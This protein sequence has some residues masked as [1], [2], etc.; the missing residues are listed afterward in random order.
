MDM[1]ALN[2]MCMVNTLWWE[3]L[4]DEMIMFQIILEHAQ[5]PQALDDPYF[6]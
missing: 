3:P 2:K 1:C 6:R 4:S 5:H